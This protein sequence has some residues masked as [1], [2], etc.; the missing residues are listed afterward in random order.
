MNMKILRKKGSSLPINISV[1]I[2][3]KGKEPNIEYYLD[4]EK[5]DFQSI[6]EFLF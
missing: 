6:K 5:K 1:K 4:N 3:S 2:S